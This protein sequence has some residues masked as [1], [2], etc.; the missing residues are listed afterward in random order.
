MPTEFIAQNGQ[1]IHTTT[2]ITVTHCTKH[3]PKAKHKRTS[4]SMG[5]GKPKQGRK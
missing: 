5:H 2:P 3:K 1:T 4:R